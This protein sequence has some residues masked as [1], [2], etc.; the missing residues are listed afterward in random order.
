MESEEYE[1]TQNFLSDAFDLLDGNKEL[2][3]DHYEIAGVVWMQE[4]MPPHQKDETI[5][6]GLA[7]RA[8][9][10]PFRGL[11]RKLRMQLRLL[12][13]PQ[14]SDLAVLP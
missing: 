6:R 14:S 2:F 4:M 13:I 3:L 5:K 10:I 12:S 1:R 9:G 11:Y 7:S 8:E